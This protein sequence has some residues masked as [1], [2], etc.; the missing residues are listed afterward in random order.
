MPDMRVGEKEVVITQASL[1]ATLLC[2]PAYGHVLTKN[3]SIAGNQLDAFAAKCVILR[4]TANHTEGMKH[5]ALAKSRRPVDYRV[6][7]KHAAFAQLH[8][9]AHHCKCADLH[10]FS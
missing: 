1:A 5:I 6:R 2:A 8:L 3:I 4:I 10:A 9:F 7:V